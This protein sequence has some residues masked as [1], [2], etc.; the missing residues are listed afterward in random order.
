MRMTRVHPVA[1]LGHSRLSQ[2]HRAVTG[3]RR[4]VDVQI[5]LAGEDGLYVSIDGRDALELLSKAKQRFAPRTTS[6]EPLA[7]ERIEQR[8]SARCKGDVCSRDFVRHAGE[9]RAQ[10][11]RCVTV[12]ALATPR[13]PGCEKST[14]LR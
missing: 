3:R 14:K 7:P 12:V 4:S 8:S 6:R 11:S 10:Q 9:R 1:A 5:E 2:F 13:E